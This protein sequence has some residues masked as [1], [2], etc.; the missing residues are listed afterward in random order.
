MK[1]NRKGLGMGLDLLLKASSNTPVR[2]VQAED[3]APIKEWLD[4]ALE[5][6]EDG[7]F[8]EA[9]YYYRLIIERSPAEEPASQVLSQALN[10]AA[11]I[12]FDNGFKEAACTYLEKALACWPD[13]TTARD[14]LKMLKNTD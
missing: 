11:T 8:L 13:N 2:T 12:L 3:T 6:D 7:F 14:N 4:K 5:Y 9:Y 1:D 10:N